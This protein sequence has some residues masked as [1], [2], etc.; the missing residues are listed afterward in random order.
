MVDLGYQDTHWVGRNG[1]EILNVNSLWD[2]FIL[3]TLSMDK[4]KCSYLGFIL[5]GLGPQGWPLG[6][7]MVDLGCQDTDWVGGNNNEGL[8]AILLTDGLI[9]PVPHLGGITI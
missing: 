6:S 1:K 2:G 7:Q 8:D 5:D 9:T 3:A 4:G